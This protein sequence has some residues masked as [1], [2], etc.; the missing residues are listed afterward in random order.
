MMAAKIGWILGTG[1][2]P[3]GQVTAIGAEDDFRLELN[4]GKGKPAPTDL[5]Q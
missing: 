2:H 1:A 5:A 4:G 3:K